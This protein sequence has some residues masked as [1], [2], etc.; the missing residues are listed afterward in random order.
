MF[1][2]VRHMFKRVAAEL[3][4]RNWFWSTYTEDCAN[5]WVILRDQFTWPPVGIVRKW[6]G[7][8]LYSRGTRMQQCFL[9]PAFLSLHS[10]LPRFSASV[11][12]LSFRHMSQFWPTYQHDQSWWCVFHLTWLLFLNSLLEKGTGISGRKRWAECS[13]SSFF[14]YGSFLSLAQMLVGKEEKW[15]WSLSVVSDSLQPHGQ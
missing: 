12:T 4:I 5:N 13:R 14:L 11:N 6:A 7:A 3:W 15:K 2:A 8:R 10:E 9:S 1:L